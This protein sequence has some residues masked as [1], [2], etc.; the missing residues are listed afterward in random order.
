MS[1]TNIRINQLISG[2]L[3]VAAITC[4]SFVYAT[5]GHDGDKTKAAQMEV[6]MAGSTDVEILVEVKVSNAEAKRL[7]LV[8]E[9]ERGD[10][11]FRKEIDKAGFHSRLRFPKDNYISEYT[12]KLKAGNKPVEQYKIATTSRMVEDITISKL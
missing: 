12:I 9:N 5:P 7:I 8:I 4:T 10:E 2:L 1:K 6:S 11:L 3:L